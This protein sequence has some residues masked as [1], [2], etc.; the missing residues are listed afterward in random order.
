MDEKCS[1]QMM[2]TGLLKECLQ[3]KSDS[4]LSLFKVNITEIY[5][6]FFHSIGGSA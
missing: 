4:I 6:H 2:Y 1:S 3:T 5:V